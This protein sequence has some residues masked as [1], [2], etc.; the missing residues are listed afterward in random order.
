M[1]FRVLAVAPAIVVLSFA[2]N[3]GAQGTSRLELAGS[4]QFLQP[5]CSVSCFNYPWGWQGSI[6]TR[7]TSWLNVLTEAGEHLKTI[8]T[9]TSGPIPLT[10]TT[11]GTLLNESTTRL[12]IYDVL[13]GPKA[14]MKIGRIR[15]FGELL[16]GVTNSTFARTDSVSIPEEGA[17]VGTSFSASVTS[18]AWQPRL[19]VDLPVTPRWGTRFSVAYRLKGASP[20]YLANEDVLLETGVVFRPG[21]LSQRP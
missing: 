2:S 8:S 14:S 6:S 21:H 5:L 19:G 17:Q 20:T 1:P 4:Y 12:R 18:W 7:V 9:T 15:M 16:F 3:A 11:A 10:A 13:V